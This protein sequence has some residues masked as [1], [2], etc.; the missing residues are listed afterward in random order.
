MVLT[1]LPYFELR[2]YLLGAIRNIVSERLQALGL[3]QIRL[4][5]SAQ[6]NEPNV[7]IFVS[8]D[9]AKKKHVIVLFYE[10][11]QDIGIF[12]HRIIGG[13]GG[14]NAG[15]AV[16]LVKYIQS[17]ETENVD[18][19]GVILA[20]MGQLRWWRRGRKAVTQVTWYSL[21]QK[22]A[23]DAP[24]R[25]DEDKNTIPGNATPTE[26]VNYMFNHVIEK[27]VNETAKLDIIGVSQGAVQVSNFLNDF[28]NFN[29]W[30]SRIN[31]FASVAPYFFVT[32]VKNKAFGEFFR[33]VS[34]FEA[35]LL[36]PTPLSRVRKTLKL[37]NISE[38]EPT[39]CPMSH[40][41]RSLQD[42]RDAAV[43]KA[44]VAQPSA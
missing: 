3:S 37:T 10:T 39:R 25:F 24:Y 27:L 11:N 40:V 9:L 5:L 38:D 31:A 15:S 29:K 30:G 19:P 22:T 36:P 13:K 6:E 17:R 43:L 4:P 41:V 7:P 20:N 34:L 12:A 18:T 32:D 21:P 44:S 8:S 26:H 42:L 14:I 28:D 33:N 2:S 16:D 1:P 23:V 35:A